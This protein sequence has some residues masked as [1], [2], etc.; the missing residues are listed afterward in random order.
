MGMLLCVPLILIGL[1]LLVI[2]LRRKPAES[3]K[4][5]SAAPVG[6]NG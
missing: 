1:V 2:V 4:P 3:A 5:V 6:K